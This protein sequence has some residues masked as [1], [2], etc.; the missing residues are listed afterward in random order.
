MGPGHARDRREQLARGLLP[1]VALR[2]QHEIGQ[3]ERASA[4]SGVRPVPASQLDIRSHGVL[5]ATLLLQDVSQQE[6]RTRS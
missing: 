1:I 3:E 5:R 4:A 6:M 2:L